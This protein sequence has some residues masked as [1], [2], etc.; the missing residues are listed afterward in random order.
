MDRVQACP[1]GPRRLAP[2]GRS[3]IS[4]LPQVGPS[5]ET[6][7][8]IH[9][10]FPPLPL[11]PDAPKPRRATSRPAPLRRLLTN[12]PVQPRAPQQYQAAAFRRFCAGYVRSNSDM[13]L[14]YLPGGPIPPGASPLSPA[15]PGCGFLSDLISPSFFPCRFNGFLHCKIIYL[16]K[17]L[18]V[19]AFIY[20]KT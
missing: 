18:A 20:K 14:K 6:A 16:Q 2:I 17:A 5:P 19:S 9:P 11:P 12:A 4:D 8:Q 13:T 1:S 7:L 15:D 10:S 3:G